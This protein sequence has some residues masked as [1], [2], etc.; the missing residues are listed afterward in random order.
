MTVNHRVVGFGT[1]LSFAGL[2]VAANVEAATKP[3]KIANY[4]VAPAVKTLQVRPKSWSDPAFGDAGW[5]H[6]SAWGRF[7]AKAGDIVTI[8]A[9]SADPGV[10]PGI[11]VWRRA[12]DDKAPNNVVPD[13]F[14]PQNATQYVYGA[15]DDQTGQDYGNIVM[16]I[17]SY[18]Y[19]ADGN[20]LIEPRLHPRKDSKPGELNLRFKAPQ[21]ASYLFVVGGINPDTGV[22]LDQSYDIRTRVTVTT[23]TTP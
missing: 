7:S 4:N 15:K 9:V 6:S 3:A 1:A 19:D 18:G 12:A 10:H 13:H 20:A 17:T 22:A 8:R 16:R 21:T 14:Y 2:L 11:S 23:P 5:T